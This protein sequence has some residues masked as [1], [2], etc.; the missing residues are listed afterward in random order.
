MK[1]ELL[2]KLKKKRENRES[3][4]NGRATPVGAP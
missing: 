1:I 3:T 2:G 4:A